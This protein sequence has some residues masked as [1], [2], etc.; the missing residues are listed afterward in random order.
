MYL[1][2]TRHLFALHF[3]PDRA[4]PRALYLYNK[5]LEARMKRLEMLADI[6][7]A[8]FNVLFSFIK[9]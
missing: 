2:R 3:Y 5:V 8:K 4:Q 9:R 1:R 6:Q 7:K